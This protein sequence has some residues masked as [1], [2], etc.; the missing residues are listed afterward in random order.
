M[1]FKF[2]LSLF[3][4]R[5]PY[6]LIFVAIGSAVGFTLATVLPPVYTAKATLVVESEQIPEGLAASTVQTAATEQ[7]QIIQ[8]RILT[9]DKLLD[10]ANRLQ[11]YAGRGTSPAQRMPADEIVADMRKRIAIDT[12]GGPTRR[13]PQQAI[14]VTVGFTAP[15]A[16]LAATVANEVVTMILQENVRMRTTVAGQT[17]EFFT[18]EVNRLDQELTR[19]GGVILAFKEKNQNALPDSIDFRRSRLAAAQEQLLQLQRE[20]AGLKDRR[21]RLVTLFQTTGRVDSGAPERN[22]T[23]DERKLQAM[24]NQLDS[25]LVVLSPQNP[26]IKVLQAQIAAQEQVV[27]EQNGQPKTDASGAQLSAYDIQ[28]ADLDG[29]LAFIKDQQQQIEARMADLQASIEATP[30]NANAL[31]TMERDYANLQ[32]QYNQAVANKARAE[33]GD[34]IETLSKGQ[35]ISV[36][37]QAI[38]PREPTSPNRPLLAAAGV[39]AGIAVGLAFVVLLEL[40]N[41]A[42]RRPIDLTNALGINAFATVPL[43][44][45]KW[46]VRRRRLIILTAFA[47]AL[48]VLP[49]GLWWVHT[50]IVPLDQLLNRLTRQIGLAL[51][52]LP[53]PRNIA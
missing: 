31:A 48:V 7:L 4:R 16:A 15:T 30:G 33:T 1:D 34:M 12:T 52:A 6:F 10:M 9:R 29:Q 5:L 44:R 11:I 20:A 41:T 25:Q 14:F 8:Q 21:D 13:G 38:A 28:L 22:L 53:T 36:I 45:T 46:Q 35:R 19:R 50:Q 43:I 49:S 17:L 32:L 42:I 40:L 18:Q 51:E 47:L 37:E 3:L 24:K 23:P 2:Y 39:G 26:K 27:A